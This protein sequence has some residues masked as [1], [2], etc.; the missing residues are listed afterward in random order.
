MALSSFLSNPPLPSTILTPP[1]ILSLLLVAFLV[2]T[3]Y[4]LYLHP[5]ASIP[6]PILAR[7]S[8][9]WTYIHSYLGDECSLIT[10][11]HT[12]HQSPVIRIAPNEICISDGS[13]LS[14]IYSEKGGFAKADFY[15]NFDIDGFGSL[16]SETDRG[17]RQPKAKS[18]VGLFSTSS[19]REGEGVLRE[20]V[21]RFVKRLERERERC[22]DDGGSA[23]VLDLSRSL[24][25]D[26]VSAYLFR[27]SYGGLEEEG[28]HG[29]SASEFVNAF[30]GVG[31]FFYLPTWIFAQLERVSGWLFETEETKESMS[32]VDAFVRSIVEAANQEDGTYPA[33]MLNAG[34]S[35]DETAAQ[36]KDLM[37]A[38]TDSSGMNLSTLCWQLARNSDM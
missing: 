30:V 6:G 17:A 16:F 32:K 22:R 12:S 23:N 5:L 31:R 36:C 13:A 2:Y 18:V 21:G 20:C 1:G 37:F 34:L 24:A 15:H 10:A 9:L 11:A 38:G 35:K 14:A 3:I 28:G 29:L 8:P 4:T 19:L 33:R 27:T 25:V 26:A 7:L